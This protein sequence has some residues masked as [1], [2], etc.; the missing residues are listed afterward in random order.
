[1][2][3]SSSNT[4]NDKECVP[5][6]ILPVST[7]QTVYL[8]NLSIQGKMTTIFNANDEIRAFKKKIKS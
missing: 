2:K 6:Q 5:R 3:S 1:M 7:E 4:I 8:T